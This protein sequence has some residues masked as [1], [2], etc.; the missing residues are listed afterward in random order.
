MTNS[1][2]DAGRKSK[3]TGGKKL[4]PEGER[5]ALLGVILL[6]IAQQM[7]LSAICRF[8]YRRELLKFPNLPLSRLPR[9]SIVMLRL[10]QGFM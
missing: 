2:S 7:L 10:L 5:G 8:T 6:L 4:D 1:E 3:V 9:T